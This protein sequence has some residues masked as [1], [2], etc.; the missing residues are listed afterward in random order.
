VAINA[1]WAENRRAAPTLVAVEFET[2]A[3]QLSAAPESGRLHSR[4]K[5]V[6]VRKMLMP[7]SRYHLYYE[8]DS[9][10]RL[11]TILAVWHVSRGQGPTL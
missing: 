9:V 11:V 5:R 1:W 3:E 2:A 7:R 6:I 4:S 10:N 8:V